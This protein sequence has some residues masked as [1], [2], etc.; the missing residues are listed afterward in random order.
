MADLDLEAVA[1]T[2]GLGDVG[3]APLP[4][5]PARA[6][7]GAVEVAV[8]VAGED[9]K[10]LVAVGAVAVTHEAE[11]LEH[12]ERAIHRRRDRRRILCTTSVHEVRGRYVAVG[13]RQDPDDCPTLPGP[14]QAALAQALANGVPGSRE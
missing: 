10:L 3:G 12:V 13:L 8:L 9:M 1:G 7:L 14:A 2:D 11:L 6:A 4:D 5:L